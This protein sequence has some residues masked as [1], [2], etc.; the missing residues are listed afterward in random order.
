M[1][2]TSERITRLKSSPIRDILQVID[3][4]EMISFAGGLPSEDSFPRISISQLDHHQLQYGATE[5]ELELREL[6]AADLCERG[7]Y[8]DA[9]QILITSGS[10]Q[11]I[12]LVAKLVVDQ[13]TKVAV[14]SPTYL[15]ALQVFSLFGAHYESYTADSIQQLQ[16]RQNIALTYVVPT[17]Q[18]PTGHCYSAMQRKAL[19]ETCDALGCLLF[20]DDPYR[21]ICY[22]E[23][24]R[25]P[26]S[27]DIQNTSWV[28]Q[29]SFSKK[30]APGLRLGYIACSKDLFDRLSLLKQAADLHSNRLSQYLITKQ[31]KESDRSNRDELLIK[32]YRR[33]RDN[34]NAALN[35]YFSDFADWRLPA[36]GLFFWIKFRSYIDLQKVLEESLSKN[37]AFMPGE[38]FYCDISAA[39]PAIRL[40]FSHATAEQ[41]EHGLSVLAGILEEAI[42]SNSLKLG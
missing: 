24:D 25:R 42:L 33:K 39:E 26:I 38:Q 35:H 2:H 15:A 1:W 3:R 37:V 30:F 4:P 19:A 40:N 23:C 27:A 20:E 8:V 32:E 7:L 21:D 16:N 29:S 9:T 22:D 11:G 13:G 31:L 5:G 36:G 18:N 14:E 6:I 12:D 28:Y 41:A 10:Q 17:F 34:F